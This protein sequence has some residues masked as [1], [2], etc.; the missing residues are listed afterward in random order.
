MGDDLKRA[1]D[2]PAGGSPVSHL[3]RR[4]LG[5][6]AATVF[7]ILLMLAASGLWARRRWA[8]RE[9]V[10]GTEAMSS[11]IPVDPR[12]AYD[13]AFLNIHPDVDFV[14]DQKCSE[15]HQEKA[16]SYQQHPMGRSLLPISQ[17]ASVQRYES[18]TN[19]P[20]GALGVL[21]QVERQRETAV[22]RQIGRDDKGQTVFES[23]DTVDYVLG[24]GMHGHSYLIDRGGYLFQ[25]PVSWFSEK[26]IWDSSPG[27]SIQTRSG[28]PVPAS[29]LF[30]HAN[31]ARP[32][33]GYINRYEEP[34]FVGQAIGCERCHGPGSLHVKNPAD[35]NTLVGADYTIVN[36][37]HLKPELRAAVCEQCHLA[38][39]ARVLR[40]GRG[41]FDFRPGLPL[42]AFWS[43]FVAAADESGPRKAVN[44]VEQMYESQCFL[45]SEE[46][47]DEG[48]RKL[49][50]TSCH[51]PH[52]HVG[53]SVRV[54]YYR[55]RCLE[56]HRQRGCSLP[57]AARRLP[58]NDDSC[59]DCHMQRFPASDIAHTASTDHHIFRRADK[60]SPR[61]ASQ[62]NHETGIVPFYR[63]RHDSNEMEAR[64]DFGIAFAHAMVE[65]LVKRKPLSTGAD[66]QA[67]DFLHEAVRHD[68]EDI[69]A[70]EAKAEVLTLTN[71][72]AEALAEYQAILSKAPD[73]E[74]SVMGAAM[75]AQNQR[76]L[77]LALFYWG[78]A[79]AINPWQPHYRAALARMLADK[80]AWEEALPE[81][82]AWLRLDPASIEARVL[83]V[84][85][86]LKTGKKDKAREQFTKIERLRPPNLQVL[87]ARFNVEVRP[88]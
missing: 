42:E 79:V 71:R 22:H 85:C 70:A 59:I 88:R 21:F 53:P 11:K 5:K 75:L 81:C 1:F 7:F 30:C 56:C 58:G 39:D 62:S 31:R 3:Q 18:E 26:Q 40:R 13:G 33:E 15:C 57:K 27:F 24:S 28:R 66:Q 49:G 60:E 72:Q 36:P 80:K 10:P 41:L 35:K 69:S 2:F 68:S 17:I 84:N 14:G 50:C 44:H 45:Q 87:Q 77:E 74:A 86:L 67:L 54:D 63:Q 65:R 12:L 20:F 76:H 6:R 8:P 19:N 9:T 83:L 52:Q 43:I 48:K 78:R 29:C 55:E 73:R 37:K 4:L 82:E 16:L 46:R 47:P 38:G 34:I 23:S 61:K 64:R 32:L 51:D 25:S